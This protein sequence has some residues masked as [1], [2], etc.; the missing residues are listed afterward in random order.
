MHLEVQG[1]RI[2]FFFKNLGSVLNSTVYHVEYRDF[3]KIKLKKIKL[4]NIAIK[5][6][7]FRI[8]I[9]GM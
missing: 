1:P 5:A 8:S 4:I 2:N 7:Y 3:D 6:I 9:H